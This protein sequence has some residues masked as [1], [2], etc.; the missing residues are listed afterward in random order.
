M[1]DEFWKRDDVRAVQDR[2]HHAERAGD[3]TA[4]LAAWDEL[5]AAYPDEIGGWSA[6][7]QFLER[8]QR[9]A[10]ALASFQ[11]SVAIRPSYPDHYN[12]ATMLLHLGRL[13]DALAE[14]DASIACN[15][16]Y[17][18]AWCNRGIVLT[19]LERKA[20]ARTSFERAE[21]VDDRLANAFRC[22]AIL[23]ND[24]GE[25]DAAAARRKRICELEPRNAGA[26]LDYAKAL[27]DAHD[28]DYVHWEP[29]GAEEQIVHALDAALAIG[30]AERQLAWA[31]AEKIMRLQR[32]AHGA[33]AARRAGLPG[34]D[35]AAPIARY[36]E[37]SAAA[38]QRFPGD[39][40][41]AEHAE[42]ARDLTA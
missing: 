25:L 33:Q 28:D 16:Q 32:I 12:A 31:W 18:P 20:E 6:R 41:F 5:V 24:L 27:G 7:G 42:D 21:T 36:V 9:F 4:A 37:A 13:D 35:D 26:H 14:L 38:M 34:V 2:A 23:L 40:W 1:S 15:A 30:V 3:H 17:A 10:D 8:R 19:R 22:H 11:R 29:G 39:A